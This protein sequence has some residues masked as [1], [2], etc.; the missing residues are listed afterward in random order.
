[1]VLLIRFVIELRSFV[2][3]FVRSLMSCR[4]FKVLLDKRFVLIIEIGKC[5]GFWI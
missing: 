3:S 4:K 2:R 5:V 1:M